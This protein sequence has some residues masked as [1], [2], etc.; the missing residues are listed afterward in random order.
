VLSPFAQ[1]RVAHAHNT[2]LAC[3]HS[4]RGPRLAGPASACAARDGTTQRGARAHT[5][6]VSA[7]RARVAR[8]PTVERLPAGHGG[9]GDSSPELL[10]DGKGE[11]NRIGGSVLRRGEGSG[12]RR[13]SCIGVEGEGGRLNTPQKKSGKRGSGSAHR[14]QAHDGGGGQTATVVRSDGVS[15][16]RT[17]TTARSGRRGQRGHGRKGCLDAGTRTGGPGAE[18]VG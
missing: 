9:G 11:E 16:L 15:R 6:A 13:R 4:A 3:V 14:G 18:S 8:A 10:V 12:G 17:R 1:L 5:G 7:L 2:G